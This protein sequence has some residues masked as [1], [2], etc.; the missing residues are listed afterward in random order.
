MSF[1]LW[2]IVIAALIVWVITVVDIFRRHLGAGKTAAWLLIAL[3]FPF[4]GPIAYWV[5]R[6]PDPDDFRHA[7]EAQRARREEAAR[8]PFDTTGP[9]V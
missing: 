7:E 9:G 4:V 6:K 1:F 8:R 3:I 2:V 5:T